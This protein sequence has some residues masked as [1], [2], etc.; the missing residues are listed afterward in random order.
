M[1]DLKSTKLMLELLE[2]RLGI[3][4]QLSELARRQLEII[5]SG[6]VVVLLEMLGRKQQAIGEL[7]MT[8][9][10]LA[11]YRE[12]V[13][14]ERIWADEKSRQRAEAVIEYSKELLKY[15]MEIDAIGERELSEQKDITEAK[16]KKLEQGSNVHAAYS[17]AA[18]PPLKG[19]SGR[20]DLKSV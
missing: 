3:I 9:R 18:P 5:R 14:E 2:K 8:E 13:P 10:E 4:E 6:D 17:N 16:L 1:S 15:V 20:F 19:N 7:E 11:P 12:D